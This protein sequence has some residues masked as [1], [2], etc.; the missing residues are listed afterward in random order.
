M[1]FQVF[2]SIFLV[3]CTCIAYRQY[4]SSEFI[5]SFKFI[6]TY[7][8]PVFEY[9]FSQSDSMHA[10]IHSSLRI[11]PLTLVKYQSVVKGASVELI[12]LIDHHSN[13]RIE[14]AITH[15][16]LA[17]FLGST[18]AKKISYKHRLKLQIMRNKKIYAPSLKWTKFN[19]F[20]TLKIIPGSQQQ[21]FWLVGTANFQFRIC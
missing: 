19:E 3:H 2:G 15:D 20:H 14:R 8:S 9:R 4:L 21:Y 5:S 6:S 1:H 18:E 12:S 10:K 16:I 17:F 11:S 7:S 13:F